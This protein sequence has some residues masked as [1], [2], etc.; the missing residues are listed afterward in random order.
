MRWGGKVPLSGGYAAQW[1]GT[2][3]GK[4]GGTQVLAGLAP[5]SQK[6][7]SDIRVIHEQAMCSSWITEANITSHQREDRYDR[8]KGGRNSAADIGPSGQR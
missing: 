5:S 4:E 1:V 6:V 8:E 7:E 2:I 3:Q